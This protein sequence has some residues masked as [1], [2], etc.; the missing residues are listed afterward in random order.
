MLEPT[1]NIWVK[2]LDWNI[3]MI[4]TAIKKSMLKWKT[5]KI[6]AYIKINKKGI[7]RILEYFH[8]SLYSTTTSVSVL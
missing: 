2:S 7:V 6:Q 3:V 1:W 4:S 5:V 8:F